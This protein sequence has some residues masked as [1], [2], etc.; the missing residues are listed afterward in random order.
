MPENTSSVALIT[1]GN[2]GIGRGI[3]LALAD[4]GVGVV[5]TYRGHADEALE[6][7]SRI[8]DAGGV[9][10]A[11]RLDVSDAASFPAFRADL[12]AALG[13]AWGRADLD[14]LVNNAGVSGDPSP[15]GDTTAEN[16]D[17]LYAVHVKGVFLLTQELAPL[18]RDGGQVLAVSSGL[19][20]FVSPPF[21]AY[22]AMKAATEVLVRYWAAE[23]GGRGISVNTIAPGPV[24]TDFGGG[25]DNLP[26]EVLASFDSQAA[27]GRI[28]QPADI[29]EFVASLLTSKSSWA[30]AQRI[31]LSGG[32]SL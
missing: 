6:L 30:T 15:L 16:L 2:R 5:V 29:G 28:G 24:A 12:T 22:A 19:T 7:V 10:R 13:D 23:L 3:A 25:M 9:A 32:F 18:L 1:G 4:A 31:E 8:T 20:R 11:L 17:H 26:S 27:L 21:S 14:F